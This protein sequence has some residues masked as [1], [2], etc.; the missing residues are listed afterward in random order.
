M[1]ELD[2]EGTTAAQGREPIS[3]AG[4][5]GADPGGALEGLAAARDQTPH[6]DAGAGGRAAE[7][8]APREVDAGAATGPEPAVP[9]HGVV[10]ENRPADVVA[11]A[12]LGGMTGTPVQPNVLQRG[13]AASPHGHPETAGEELVDTAPPVILEGKKDV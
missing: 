7:E 10:D 8:V 3:T 9:R 11:Q 2:T 5:P 13:D 12:G 6:A 1:A 4:V